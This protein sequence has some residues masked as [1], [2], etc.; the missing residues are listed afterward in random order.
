MGQ[1]FYWKDRNVWNQREVV[2]AHPWE[3]GKCH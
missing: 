3:C 2:V 1:E